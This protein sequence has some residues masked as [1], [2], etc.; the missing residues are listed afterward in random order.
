MKRKRFAVLDR[1]GVATYFVHGTSIR[2]TYGSLVELLDINVNINEPSLGEYTKGLISLGA[3]E[4]VVEVVN[5]SSEA[6][7]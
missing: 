1:T 5:V 6:P 2:A 3:G 4:S 7:E